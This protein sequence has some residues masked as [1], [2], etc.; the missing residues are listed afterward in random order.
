MPTDRGSSDAVGTHL[1]DVVVLGSLLYRVSLALTPEARG[2]NR[3]NGQ[4]LKR[5]QDIAHV[6]VREVT[7]LLGMVCVVQLGPP[8]VAD[9]FFTG[10][11]RSRSLT[12][13]DH[14]AMTLGDRSDVHERKHCLGLEQLHPAHS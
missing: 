8:C 13:G 14:E 10:A 7:E 1:K 11:Q 6:L 5:R 9:L 3:C 12:F 2:T 4:L